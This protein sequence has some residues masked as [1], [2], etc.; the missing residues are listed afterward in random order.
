MLRREDLL[1]SLRAHGLNIDRSS[2]H[3]VLGGQGNLKF[4]VITD[5]YNYLVKV[6]RTARKEDVER[7]YTITSFLNRKGHNVQ[8]PVR[9]GSEPVVLQIDRFVIGIFEYINGCTPPAT[10]T[11][12]ES[13]GTEIAKYQQYAPTQIPA[14]SRFQISL[15]S[16]EQALSRGLILD[17]ELVQFFVAGIRLCKSATALKLSLFSHCD[18]F[19]DN[20]VADNFGKIFII[21]FEEA[22]FETPLL[23]LGSVLIG[24]NAGK[25]V[26]NLDHIL[27]LE[28]GY[29]RGLKCFEKNI[30]EQLLCLIRDPRSEFFR[31]AIV[32]SSLIWTFWRWRRYCLESK[33]DV[34][35]SVRKDLIPLGCSLL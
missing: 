22:A 25:K 29:A 30:S 23:E 6:Y 13:L 33:I 8:R 24:C 18:L 9:L 5:S 20:I 11:L 31:T 32:Y 19:L 34:L 17:N 7:E 26:V 21:D 1:N 2:L 27:A 16:I 28:Q 15:S 3:I 10:N 35:S 4:R 12:I 14:K